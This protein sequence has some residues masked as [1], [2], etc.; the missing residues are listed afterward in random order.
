[1]RRS[2][3]D[4]F[5]T[6]LIAKIYHA[7]GDYPRA[8]AQFQ[9]I[10]KICEEMPGR[11]K[12]GIAAV[13][14]DLA[15]VYEANGDYARALQARAQ[16]NE[17]RERDLTIILTPSMDDQYSDSQSPLAKHPSP[18]ARQFAR[19]LDQI[20]S[21][22]LTIIF[23]AEN[24]KQ[25]F[26]T[27][28]SRET[29]GTVSLH[30][31]H[32]PLDKQ[33]T[34]LALTTI[35]QRKGRVLDATADQINVLRRYGTPQ[36]QK[37][38]NQLTRAYAR[39]AALSNEDSETPLTRARN[40]FLGDKQKARAQGIPDEEILRRS[41]GEYMAA[42]AAPNDP[43]QIQQEL[44]QLEKAISQRSAELR[45]PELPVTLNAVRQAL[46][47]NAALVEIFLYEP[48]DP[49]KVV[50]TGVADMLQQSTSRMQQLVQQ[51]ERR[52]QEIQRNSQQLSNEPPR[53]QR[54]TPQSQPNSREQSVVK[55]DEEALSGPRYVAYVLR[56]DEDVPRWVELGSAASINATVTQLREALRDRQRTDT[57]ELARAMDERIMR[58]IRKRIGPTK[59]IFL[60]PDGAL[61]L[62]PFAA[63][64]DEKNQYLIENYSINYLTTGR[65]LLS[66]QTKRESRDELSVFANPLFDMS[67]GKQPT[68]A[69]KQVSS[70]ANQAEANPLS[71]NL[72]VVRY[73]PLPGTAAE[74][75]ALGQL[76]PSATVLTQEDATEAA[77]K[78]VNRPRLLH[79]ATH[80]FFLADQVEG[81][82]AGNAVDSSIYTQTPGN[83]SIPSIRAPG[84][85]PESRINSAVRWR[86]PLLRSGLILAGINQRSSGPEEDGLL[87]ALEVAGLDL[88]GTKLV[89]LSACQ[90]GLGDVKN[91]EGVYGLRRAL[92]LAGSETQVMSLW[93]VSDAGTRDLMVAYYTRLKQGESRTEAMRQ[94]QLA[95]LLG[96]LTPEGN[97]PINSRDT[98][99][100]SDTAATKDY[101]HPYYWAAFI[102]SGDWRNMEGT[103]AQSR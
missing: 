100:V 80:G 46:P 93:K 59:R 26:L 30:V 58:P 48:F 38:I 81:G 33:A 85:R 71:K 49:R 42:M 77:L 101:S 94:V 16:G 37:L 96:K 47:A 54:G 62:I 22:G 25:D 27:S 5:P 82:G 3:Y 15:T 98:G 69:G 45:K 92:V 60:A 87:T 90:T 70:P 84:C 44:E 63:L 79:I 99:E 91:G 29:N 9:R 1:M 43:D 32:L 4:S 28:I 95:M 51:A 102:P 19:D 103:E 56:R 36:D 64:V 23:G 17:R 10:L 86:L 35:L 21:R 53:S 12:F 6:Y 88:W 52:A 66:L 31:R 11:G 89:V 40:N 61:T 50:A 97:K 76:F 74:A 73:K 67:A 2:A 20:A 55:E 41:Q 83:L 78:R 18:L 34:Q 8:E 72:S 14:N 7:K 65:D 68:G 75:I 57:R 24:R 13:L 39:V